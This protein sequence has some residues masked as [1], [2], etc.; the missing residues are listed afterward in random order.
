MNYIITIFVT[1]IES[2]RMR[3]TNQLRKHVNTFS[4]CFTDE[5]GIIDGCQEN[6]N[7]SSMSAYYSSY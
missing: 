4:K 6:V 1:N 5:F 2:L 3:S 7:R